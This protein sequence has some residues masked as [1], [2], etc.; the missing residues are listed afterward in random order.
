MIAIQNQCFLKKKIFISPFGKTFYLLY[1][2]KSRESFLSRLLI[3]SY[4]QTLVTIFVWLRSGPTEK[5]EIGTPVNCEM[6]SR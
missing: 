2:K 6:R 4:R 1:T 5:I 3:N